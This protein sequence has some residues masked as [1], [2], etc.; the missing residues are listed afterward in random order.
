MIQKKKTSV[1]SYDGKIYNANCLKKYLIEKGYKFKTNT[2]KELIL[3]LYKNLG[4]DCLKKL[5]GPFA[6]AIYDKE[7]K[8]FFLARDH[9]GIKPLYY[10]FKKGL[11]LFAPELKVIINN[12]RVKKEL[13]FEALNQYFSTGFGCIPAP[14]T[15]FK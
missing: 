10:Y 2:D 11:F 12:P 7:R 15:I 3:H 1:I 4:P 9:F 13:D 14:R 8:L 6:F 5:H